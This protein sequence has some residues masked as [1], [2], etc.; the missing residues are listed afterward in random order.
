M[1]ASKRICS[2]FAATSGCE[3]GSGSA[4]PTVEEPVWG[5]VCVNAGAEVVDSAG[6]CEGV[7]VDSTG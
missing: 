1:L 3:A 4:D 7:A 2:M 5:N 6:T